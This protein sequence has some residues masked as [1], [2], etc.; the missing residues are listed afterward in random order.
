[1]KKLL[2]FLALSITVLSY[3]VFSYDAV[4]KDNRGRVTG[5]MDTQGDKTYFI[6]KRGRR[7]DYIEA[8]GTIKDKYGRKKGKIE[9]K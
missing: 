1:M 3:S 6:D 4:I 2:N 7:G 9:K 8:D 5:Y